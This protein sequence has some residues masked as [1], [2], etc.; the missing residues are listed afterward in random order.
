MKP[1]LKKSAYWAFGIALHAILISAA[2]GSVHAEP[3]NCRELYGA[4]K[5]V[6]MY[7][8]FSCE[9]DELAPL[10]ASYEA[11]CM[12]SVVPAS[13]FGFDSS[14][15]PSALLPTCGEQRARYAALPEL[16]VRK[17]QP[18]LKDMQG[19][20]TLQRPPGGHRLDQDRPGAAAGRSHP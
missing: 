1:E 13:A 10:Q 7:C 5:S 20:G 17:D 9:Q 16:G 18:L 8:G 11:Q 14:P 4:I 6:A 3:R 2:A 15:E 12:V 19:I